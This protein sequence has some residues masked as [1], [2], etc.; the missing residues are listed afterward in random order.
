[1]YLTGYLFW[2][3]WAG[4]LEHHQ[5]NNGWQIIFIFSCHKVPNCSLPNYTEAAAY[6]IQLH[7]SQR[8]S[9]ICFFTPVTHLFLSIPCL[10]L[11]LPLCPN[12]W[13][14]NTGICVDCCVTVAK[15]CLFWSYDLMWETPVHNDA[16][17]F[18]W[19]SIIVSV[20]SSLL[21]V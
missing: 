19:P 17:V 14:A 12:L 20:V 21:V 18:H 16:H 15:P 8:V 4:Q 11:I 9:F 3:P 1:M 10:L 5:L 6:S 2:I 7:C 13:H